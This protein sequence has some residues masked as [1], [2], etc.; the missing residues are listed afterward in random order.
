MTTRDDD[1]EFVV[2]HNPTIKLTSSGSNATLANTIN[3]NNNNTNS[4]QSI[5][6]QSA[7]PEA[8]RAIRVEPLNRL[9]GSGG[10]SLRSARSENI[11]ASSGSLGKP[12]PTA[13]RSAQQSSSS[14]SKSSGQRASTRQ[15]ATNGGQV[16]VSTVSKSSSSSRSI[17]PAT[18]APVQLANNNNNNNHTGRPAVKLSTSR[19]LLN[20][21]LTFVLFLVALVSG[22]SLTS[23]GL[24]VD[25]NQRETSGSS[26]A[27]DD[28]P[29]ASTAAASGV[30]LNFNLSVLIGVAILAYSICGLVM[31]C[32]RRLPGKYLPCWLVTSGLSLFAIL[33]VAG[34]GARDDPNS[35]E[36]NINSVGL[37][38][39]PNKPK[40]TW[41]I[42]AMQLVQAR[43]GLS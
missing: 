8:T 42:H 39:T 13:S 19:L 37:Q 16:V 10:G 2:S 14:S 32:M 1:D 3:N 35:G 24:F 28:D 18:V 4:G 5:V 36:F 11:V 22:L 17:R 30:Q 43:A 9:G 38:Q 23:A 20:E 7:Q 27:S 6:S 31:N 34:S 40:L 33:I 29:I 26:G 12:G 15:Q 25:K 41:P 21:T